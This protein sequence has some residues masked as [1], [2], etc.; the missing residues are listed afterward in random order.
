VFSFQEDYLRILRYFRFYGRLA[1]DS[2]Q[3]EAD[4]I[5][6]IAENVDGMARISGERIW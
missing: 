1:S 3:H 6:A 2:L 4:T 5:K